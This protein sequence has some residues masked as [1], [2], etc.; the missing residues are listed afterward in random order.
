M[1]EN[2]MME[3]V[4][5]ALI[6]FV[7]LTLMFVWLDRTVSLKVRQMADQVEEKYARKVMILPLKEKPQIELTETEMKLRERAKNTPETH[8]QTAGLRIWK[9]SEADAG[10][11]SGTS[12]ECLDPEE[13]QLSEDNAA[14][15]EVQLLGAG[16]AGWTV[17]QKDPEDPYFS[18]GH[19]IDPVLVPEGMRVN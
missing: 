9:P 10:L 19:G 11:G 14:W 2:G 18:E 13:V 12:S 16:S 8:W 3:T 6:L 1:K 17:E 15:E 7:S 4:V 5:N